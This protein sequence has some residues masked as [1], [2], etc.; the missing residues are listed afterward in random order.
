M[1]S[2]LKLLSQQSEADNWKLFTESLGEY[3]THV[4]KSGLKEYHSVY[5][6]IVELGQKLL[7]AWA[8]KTAR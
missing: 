5:P 6:V 7:T 1:D 3:Q 4:N 8:A 2:Y